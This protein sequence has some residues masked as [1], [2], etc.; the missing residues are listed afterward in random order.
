MEKKIK[1]FQRLATL[2]KR[3]IS[4]NVA[5]SNLLETEIVK[6][7]K[8]ISQIDDIMDNSKID[9]SQNIINSGF[10]KN[11]AQLLST[12]QS[13]K[14]IASNRNN[15]LLNEQNIVKKKI[16]VNRLKKIKAEEKTNEYKLIYSNELEKKS[17][18]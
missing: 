11:N 3:D 14:N 2:Q 5:N 1:R 16:I 12:L 4:K 9:G 18:D 13:Q 8:L 17:Y 6:N 10:F 15:Y 7:K